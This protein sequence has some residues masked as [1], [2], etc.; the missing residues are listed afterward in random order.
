[1]L[2]L[3]VQIKNAKL[4]YMQLRVKRRNSFLD[5]NST[6]TTARREVKSKKNASETERDVQEDEGQV[7]ASLLKATRTNFVRELNEAGHTYGTIE[8]V[9]AQCSSSIWRCRSRDSSCRR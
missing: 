9:K 3:Q 5:L 7:G 6:I 1:M 8:A 2:K 4:A